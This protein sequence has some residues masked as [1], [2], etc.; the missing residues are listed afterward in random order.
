MQTICTLLQTNN[1]TSTPPLNFYRPDALPDAQ[2]TVPQQ[3]F[4]FTY[5]FCY[6][7]CQLVYGFVNALYGI[8]FS[9]QMPTENTAD[10]DI[11]LLLE[12]CSSVC[13]LFVTLKT[14]AIFL[15]VY[16]GFREK[17]DHQS[18]VVFPEEKS[19]LHETPAFLFLSLWRHSNIM[20]HSPASHT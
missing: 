20:P 15:W 1:H 12:F 10:D 16:R 9:C 8:V 6:F 13:R 14:A 2:P 18:V 7:G 17:L 3:I 19:Q 4:L 11:S 5:N